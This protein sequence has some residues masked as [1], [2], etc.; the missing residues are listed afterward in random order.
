MK[1]KIIRIE[2]DVTPPLRVVIKETNDELEAKLFYKR[3]KVNETYNLKYE[4]IEEDGKD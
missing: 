2:S 3:I 4:F 1:Y